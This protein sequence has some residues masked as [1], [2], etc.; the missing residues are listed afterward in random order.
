[1]Q[2]FGLLSKLITLFAITATGCNSP[3]TEELALQQFSTKP[4][5]ETRRVLLVVNKASDDSRAIAEYYRKR[6]GIPPENVVTLDCTRSDNVSIPEYETAIL[7]PIRAHL[8]NSRNAID[9]IVLTKGVP[10]RLRDSNGYSVDGH[11]AA[12]D[13]N[14]Q[15]IDK[16]DE[17]SVRKSINPF[18][19]KNERFSHKKFGL[20]LV[21]RLDG[22]EVEHVKRM[23]ENSMKAKAETGLFFFDAAPE[24]K[25]AGYLDMQQTLQRAEKVL[26][27]KGYV[28][29]IDELD[30]FVSPTDLLM[31]YASWGS[32][33]AHF[34][35]ETYRKLRFRPGA[36]AETF[37]S[38]SGRSFSRTTDG[39]SMIADLIEAGVTG[40]KGYVSEPFT[41]ALARPD[42]LLDR[43]TSGFNLAESFYMASPLAK[44][45]DVVIGDPI[46]NPYF[47]NEAITSN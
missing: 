5:A 45:K 35:L 3:S 18:F 7:Q 10:I 43:Y 8:Q 23:I 1:M 14:I 19:G 6:R 46:C 42:I 4:T 47:K 29:Q 24:K 12:M 22:Y 40:C 9:F 25:Q 30:S 38:T 32:N 33:D 28:S 26:R 21:T 27:A 2:Y 34:N 44:W 11:L 36:L 13:L 41:V 17:P 39:Q 15:A 31:G 37:V 16:F 20:Y